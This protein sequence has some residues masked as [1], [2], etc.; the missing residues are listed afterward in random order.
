MSFSY[1]V[2]TSTTAVVII[3]SLITMGFIVND[4]NQLHSEIHVEMSEFRVSTV[5]ISPATGFS[6]SFNSSG[7]G[8]WRLEPDH[9]WV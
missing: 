6:M 5:R 1:T 3:V 9:G 2:G 8:E 7:D 4:I